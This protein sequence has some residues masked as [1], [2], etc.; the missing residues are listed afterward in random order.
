MNCDPTPKS[1]HDSLPDVGQPGPA[2]TNT[3]ASE[4]REIALAELML[5]PALQCRAELDAEAIRDYA[6]LISSGSLP[7]P[8]IVYDI[9]GTLHV[10]DGA[11]RYYAA[12]KAG[13]VTIQAYVRSGTFDEALKHA[14]NANDKHGVRVKRKDKRHRVALATIRWPLLSNR[15]IAEVCG[16]SPGLVDEVVKKKANCLK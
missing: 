6:E 15:L 10:V 11:H 14:L 2:G 8:I 3:E 4:L 13:V 7:P 1:K 16:V 9:G 5:D 12:R